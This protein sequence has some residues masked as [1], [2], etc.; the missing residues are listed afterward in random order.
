MKTKK[1]LEKISKKKSLEKLVFFHFA[2]LFFFSFFL[3]IACDTYISFTA[4]N[5]SF[6]VFIFLCHNI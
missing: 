6:I 4:T 1:I 3:I 2:V 5:K